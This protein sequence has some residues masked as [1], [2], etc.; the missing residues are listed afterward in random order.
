MLLINC[1]IALSF[2]VFVYCGIKN[3]EAK[4]GDGKYSLLQFMC[5]HNIS[6]ALK[7]TY[8]ALNMFDW[9]IVKIC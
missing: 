9:T 2:S 8:L 4:S 3:L 1:L 6:S 7:Q 5:F